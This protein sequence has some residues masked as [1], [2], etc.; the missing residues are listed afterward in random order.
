ME[1]AFYLDSTFVRMFIS[2]YS[3]SWIIF[4]FQ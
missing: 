3:Q 1:T 4:K 2:L